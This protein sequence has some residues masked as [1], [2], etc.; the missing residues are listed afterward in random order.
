MK[1]LIVIVLAVALLASFSGCHFYYYQQYDLTG[2]W[3]LSYVQL[4]S[5]PGPYDHNM[6]ITTQN[7]DGS[8]SGTGNYPAGIWTWSVTGSLTD[9]TVSMTITYDQAV[10]GTSPYIVSLTG[11]VG[12]CG[13]SMSG[14]ASDNKGYD[15]T[16][17]ATRVP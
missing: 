2:D 17:T 5:T 8:F 7:I 13:S 3:A 15:Y 4:S 14:T 6:S 1:K 9:S 12:T 16:W 11:T 10:G